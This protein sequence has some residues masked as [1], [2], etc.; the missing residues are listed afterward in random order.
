MTAV[1]ALSSVRDKGA[2]QLLSHLAAD[3]NPEVSKAAVLGLWS[4]GA[5]A[6]LRSIVEKLNGAPVVA[7]LEALGAGHEV[8]QGRSGVRAKAGAGLFT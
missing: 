6:E 4:Q 7:A 8:L 1:L 2:Q 3:P 5:R